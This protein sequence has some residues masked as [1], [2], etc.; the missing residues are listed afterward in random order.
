[1]ST[2]ALHPPIPRQIAKTAESAQPR[3]ATC[4]GFSVECVDFDAMTAARAAWADLVTR[5]LEPNA[6]L[7]PGFAIPLFQHC[8]NGKEPR[9]ILAWTG[10]G[11][12]PRARLIGLMPLSLSGS[13]FPRFARG[14]SHKQGPLG[15]PLFDRIQGAEALRQIISWLHQHYPRMPGLLLGLMPT[16]GPTF[17]LLQ[18]YADTMRS[19]LIRFNA[20]ERAVLWRPDAEAA[21]QGFISKKRRKQYRQQRRRL[22]ESGDIV[23]RTVQ[24]P[25]AIRQATEDFL[26]LE[27]KGWKGAHHTALLAAPS[28]TAFVRAMTRLMADE[29][30]CRI[31][32]LAFKGRPIAMGI[33]LRSG[34]RA[35]YWKTT[36]DERFALYSPGVQLT[37]ELTQTQI[38]NAAVAL[39]DSCAMP[40]HPMIDH[41]WKD[42]LAMAEIL[43]PLRHSHQVSFVIC[44][45][46]E[47][48]YRSLRQAAKSM[49]LR[50]RS[51]HARGA[52][53]QNS[54][55][56]Q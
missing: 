3:G 14:L 6:F 52:P 44:L 20:H 24:N 8:E 30:K 41:L 35:Y 21:V 4:A 1:M 40:S 46:Q 10:E 27:F 5:A 13:L 12:D 22:E 7:E 42:R 37:L 53:N 51:R 47:I 28:E 9:F 11:N 38:E 31:D 49:L 29:G 48:A 18:A 45:W 50:F 17:A 16:Q 56:A 25:G 39:T 34:D 26:A 33:V 54:K 15:T 2:L 43:L 32:S 23:Y 36:Y 55:G 19:G